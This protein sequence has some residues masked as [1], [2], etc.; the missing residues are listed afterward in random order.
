MTIGDL[1]RLLS[2][3]EYHSGEKL[4]EQ[5]GVSR[6]AV[7]KQLKK[8]EKIGLQWE[9]VKGQGY[10]L[11]TP[12]DL[13]SGPAIIERLPAEP[14]HHLTRLFVEDA[15][16][17]TNT[18]LR[19]RFQ[20]GAGHAEVCLAESQDAGRGRRGRHWVCPWGSG[21]LFSLGWRFD[22]GASALEG[23]SLAV[24]VVLA[25]VLERLS[26]PVALKWPNDLLL[27]RSDGS[28]AKLAG[29][30]LEVSGDV[31]G[32]CEVVIGIGL[33]VALPDAVRDSVDQPVAALNDVRSDITR[34]ELSASL[35]EAL[36]GMLP[37]FEQHG[38]EPWRDA[39][40]RRNAYAGLEVDVVQGGHAY[41]AVVESVDATGNLQVNV[42]GEARLLAGGEI[43]LR[44]RS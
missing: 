34:N 37:L 25:E 30:L 11:A 5:L 10:R 1:I 20:Q 33:N 44:A 3:G 41:T 2:D 24:G 39:W 27:Q 9:A 13:L 19:E 38:F 15:L 22:E 35:V 18:F 36:L 21:L 7:W 12:L 4:G 42:N 23:L 29:I 6:T 16:P 17:S 43:S 32:P 31:A 26:V 14:R 28:T 8:L 40:N